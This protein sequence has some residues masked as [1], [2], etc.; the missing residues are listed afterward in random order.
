MYNYYSLLVMYQQELNSRRLA[1]NSVN[2]EKDE[3][4]FQLLVA[5]K[6]IKKMQTESKTIIKMYRKLK[7]KEKDEV[8]VL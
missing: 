5:Q 3:L 2:T 1:Y 7:D 4:K 6:K 8:C